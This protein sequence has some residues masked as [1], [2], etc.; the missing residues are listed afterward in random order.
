MRWLIYE[1]G[2][3][4]S[5]ERL[6][7]YTGDKYGQKMFVDMND[8]RGWRGDVIKFL[9]RVENGI[10]RNVFKA[11]DRIMSSADYELEKSVTAPLRQVKESLIDT[12]LREKD[13]HSRYSIAPLTDTRYLE[14]RS[15]RKDVLFS[16]EFDGR[17]K[18]VSYTSEKGTT[19]HNTAF[20][21][22][23][24]DG[25]LVSMDIRNERFNRVAGAIVSVG[26]A[27]RSYVAFKP[28]L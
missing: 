8:Q 9:E 5:K 22:Y 1:R 3:K 12:K 14:G 27:G 23:A 11:V 6:A 4:G 21:M 10:Y 2:E 18:T 26:G 17:I 28:V 13:L 25:H 24:Q 7:V 16:P 15:L 20:P 19:H